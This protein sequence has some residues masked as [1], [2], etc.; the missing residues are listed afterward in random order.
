[1]VNNY[2]VILELYEQQ[3]YMFDN[4]VNRVDNR[5]VSISQPLHRNLPEK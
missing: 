3:K 2:L 1:M 4:K 5:I